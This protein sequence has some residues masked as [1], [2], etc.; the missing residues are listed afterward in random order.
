MAQS[1][2]RAHNRVAVSMSAEVSRA[3]SS[4]FTAVT[5]NLS[6]AGAA[7]DGD[8]ALTDGEAVR[9][10]LFVVVE[11]IEDE[12]TPP[13]IVGARVQ[14]TAEGDAGNHT[15]GVHFE[16]ITDAQAEWLGRMIA[17]SG[18]KP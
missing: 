10:A 8:E 11:G 1:E 17:V 7:L 6:V 13:L 4:M 14:W 5:L 2:Q 9:L 12:R 15:A 18:A 3:D 16:D